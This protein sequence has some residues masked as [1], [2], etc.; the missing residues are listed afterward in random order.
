MMA[1]RSLL[2]VIPPTNYQ[3]TTMIVV[4]MKATAWISP[5]EIS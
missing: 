5:S 3:M 4:C 2:A 1:A